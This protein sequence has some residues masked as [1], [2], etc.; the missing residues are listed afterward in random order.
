V[1]LTPPPYSPRHRTALVLVGTGTAGAYHAGVLRALH[2]A[3]VRIDLV[4]GR[5]MGAVSAMFTAVDAG[6]RLWDEK[7]MWADPR[8][9]R[10][11]YR[12]KRLWL[13][14]GL[15][16][17]AATLALL[18]PLAVLLLA[19]V[20]YPV[21]LVVQLVSPAVGETVAALYTDVVTATLG[22]AMLSTLVPRVAT[23]G[24][25]MFTLAA[26]AGALVAVLSRRRRRTRGP[27]WARAFGAP[28]ETGH[29]FDWAT[30]G[31]WQF[32]RGAAS[33]AQPGSADLARRY[34]ELLAENL[35]QP[36][37]RELLL[38][39]HDLDARRDL[40]FALLAEPY[41]RGFT[42]PVTRADAARRLAELGDLA[43]VA[44]EHVMDA[45]AGALSVPVVTDPY[46]MTF[47]SENHWRG[48]TH[49][50]T[51]RPAAITRLLEEVAA[52]G[53]EQVLVVSAV[54]D[55]AGP[56]ALSAPRLDLRSRVG[57]YVMAAEA[58]AL[59]DAVAAHAQ[60]F[61]GFYEIRPVHNPIGPFDLDGGYDDRSDRVQTLRE[62]MN[63]G[64][65]DAYRQFIE[66]MVGASGE[67]IRGTTVLK[68]VEDLPINPGAP[69][70]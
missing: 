2:E 10:R 45:L 37:Y 60:G 25:V 52:A 61:A 22:P 59:R 18:V 26:L 35:G 13:M 33:I 9:A 12:W 64:Y 23:I 63:R 39:A 50:L 36:G 69:E 17:A 47:A 70:R 65:E 46:P 16:L 19:V 53:A 5:G 67:A 57:D 41:R 1:A 44:A 20:A 6:A 11:L 27:F 42:S 40:V 68:R 31:F 3:G 14:A 56:H 58:A 15:G 48:E 66:P 28:F 38:T 29:A 49:R 32:I 34:A 51:D 4:A 62:L 55:L 30:G 21:A 54:H 43:G 8:A 7:G 24:V